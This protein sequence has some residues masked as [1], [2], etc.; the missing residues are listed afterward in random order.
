MQYGTGQHRSVT[1]KYSGLFHCPQC[2]HKNALTLVGLE[3]NRETFPA[4]VTWH[5]AY[6]DASRHIHVRHCQHATHTNTPPH[7]HLLECDITEQLHIYTTLVSVR[8]HHHHPPASLLPEIN[9]NPTR[10]Q[11][12]TQT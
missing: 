9:S 8:T 5:M 11:R 3:T 7:T 12:E 2:T 10:H 4:Q 6:K 1:A